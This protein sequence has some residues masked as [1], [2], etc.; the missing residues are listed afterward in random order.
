[1]S[2]A[3]LSEALFKLFDILV[4]ATRWHKS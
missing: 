3:L 4:A 1:L 2:F